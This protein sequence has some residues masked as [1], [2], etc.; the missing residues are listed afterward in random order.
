MGTENSALFKIELIN[1]TIAHIE[2]A[3]AKL[4][5]TNQSLMTAV[6]RL[7]GQMEEII[8][9]KQTVTKNDRDILELQIK[10]KA[11]E[12]VAKNVKDLNDAVKKH[13]WVN[14]IGIF[15]VT[16]VASGIISLMIKSF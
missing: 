15:L 10:V 1:T 6:A 7:S 13:T 8:E 9:L 5:D 4:S 2:E 16:I 3:L 12:D 14:Q 11:I